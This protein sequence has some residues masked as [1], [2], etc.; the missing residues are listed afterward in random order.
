MS[1]L[2]D[3][4]RALSPWPSQRFKSLP[5]AFERAAEKHR[6]R[7]ALGAGSWQ[8]TY[9]GLNTS[10]NCF[11]HAL[12]R[13]PGAQGDRVA[14]LMQHDTP[15]IGAVLAVLKAGRIAVALNPMHPPARLR[16]VIE[17][18]EPAL[19]VT[20]SAHH[21][22]AA[23]IAPPSCS[24][25]QF[26]HEVA[27]GSIFNPSLA[28]GADETAFL[29]YTSGSTGRP[30]AVMQ[31]H[32][33]QL[34]A[35]RIYTE[36]MEYT[37][38]DRIPLFGS[39]SA[40][41]GV[42]AMW[43]A[44]LNGGTLCPFPIAVNG[45]TGLRAW[46]IDQGITAYSSSA[47]IFRQFMKSIDNDV[48]FPLVRAVRLSSESATSS[49]FALFQRHFAEPCKFVHTLSSSETANIS[50]SRLS[51]NDEVPE[52]RLEI[53]TLSKGI[54]LLLLDEGNQPVKPGEV[55]DIVVRG[56][57]LAAGYWRRPALTA[58][59]FS[60]DI[61][62]IRQFRSG[63]LGRINSEGLLEYV[64]RAD[65]RVKIRGNRVELAE[66]EDALQQL[67]AVERAVVISTERDNHEH[68]L[69]GYVVTAGSRCWSETGLRMALGD[70][71]PHHMIPS[72]MVLLDSFPVTP[73]G[74]I[75]RE[76][77]RQLSPL[78]QQQSITKPS[79]QSTSGDPR[80]KIQQTLLGLW[81]DVLK[82][83]DIGC[84][85]DFFLLGGDS[86]SAVD[87]LHRI[88]SELQYQVPITILA[89]APTVRQLE[90]SLQKSTRGAINDMIRIH[91]AGSRR[92]LFALAGRYGH[93]LRLLPVL[94]SLG[95][96]QPCYGLQPP[97]MD[98]TG[99]GCATLHQMAAHYIGKVKEVQ[100]RGPYRLLGSSF[101]GLV[102]FE[103]ALQL[104]KMGESVEFLGLID[105]SP[106]TC[107]FDGSTDV[108]H[109]RMLKDEPPPGPDSF[110]ALNLRVAETHVSAR[111]T[112][113][114]DNRS[115]QGL[116]H[117][118]MT[119]FY[120]TGNPIIA[121]HDRRRLWRYY[122]PELRLLPLPGVHGTM[123]AEPQA[124]ALQDLLRACL[125][126]EPVAAS[127]PARVFDQTFRIENC[128]QHECII[129]STGDVYRVEQ[130]R[131]QGYVQ[132]LEADSEAIRLRGWA[133]EPCLQQAAHNIAVFHDNRF[134][135]YGASGIL[136]PKV[137][138]QLQ[139]ISAQYAGF[140]FDLGPVAADG[141]SGQFRLFV[142]SSDG[143]A[144]ELR[145]TANRAQPPLP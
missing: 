109:P 37:A 124:T 59:R 76:Q 44:L 13:H 51:R 35:A 122:T 67:P 115:D 112:Y 102:V 60:G 65:S 79:A 116:F 145:F 53:G 81:C 72:A 7:T 134:L 15:L 143:H 31:T 125:D 58:E 45:S 8:P 32:G 19:M 25:I 84:D 70:L 86:L 111:R 92:P 123:H 43:C 132:S 107:L 29:V 17:D 26:E 38:N 33:L 47:S 78:L 136:K 96:D 49:D 3:K 12:L 97:G 138:E 106:A 5:A 105:T 119:Y 16:Q 120:C 27:A 71:L 75:D 114:L 140:N 36:A 66:V 23:A 90:A 131:I 62:G 6:H 100:P 87:L 1:R 83:R 127:T 108:E 101:G 99:A 144:A 80:T 42:V 135:G 93:V 11:A 22:L 104:Q 88:E 141:A 73:S 46:M 52:G 69:T 118:T 129:S 89:E 133:V 50:V 103:M 9:Q 28:I 21:D 18:A 57:Y 56:R 20:D 4:L 77:L 85:D 40:G 41:H 68:W 91:T 117:G 74:K 48:K 142:L 110:E 95:P 2:L 63:D 82:R 113:V 61:C 126:G 128:G 30:K 64:G 137:A 94:R 39:L 14:L 139:A 55:G 121:G 54:E 10:A 24:I 98:W 34:R 130:D